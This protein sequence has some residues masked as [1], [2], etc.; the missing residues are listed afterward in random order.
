MSGRTDSMRKVAIV[1]SALMALS[2]GCARQEG[3][4][5]VADNS[6]R[7]YQLVD[8]A[9][10]PVEGE[11]SFLKVAIPTEYLDTRILPP[12]PEG[13]A[14]ALF[15]SVPSSLESTR[16]HF[17]RMTYSSPNPSGTVGEGFPVDPYLARRIGLPSGFDCRKGI[18][19]NEGR[20]LPPDMVTYYC[21]DPSLRAS[22]GQLETSCHFYNTRPTATCLLSLR[23]PS[24]AYLDCEY[25]P[26]DVSNIRT[27]A[28][29]MATSLEPFVRRPE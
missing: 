14:R 22:G 11:P 25:P 1:A 19:R 12:P 10:S 21:E 4:N 8:R 5:S 6:V 3:N 15:V 13:E 29:D 23:I 7:H 16:R 26:S 18:D 20:P 28:E 9:V 27:M 2:S 17:C 24:R